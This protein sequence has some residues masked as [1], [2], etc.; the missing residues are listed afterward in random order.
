[1]CVMYVTLTFDC[2]GMMHDISCI[3][4]VTSC[5]VVTL[6]GTINVCGCKSMISQRKS[7]ILYVVHLAACKLST[8][9]ETGWIPVM[10]NKARPAHSTVFE[11]Y[12]GDSI[13]ISP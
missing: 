1:M 11:A 7:V 12:A 4:L 2:V 6:I 8:G 9:D 3:G 13:S 10:V 5:Y